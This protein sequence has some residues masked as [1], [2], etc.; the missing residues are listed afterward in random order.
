[1]LKGTASFT[2]SKSVKILETGEVLTGEKFILA[3]G[4]IPAKLSIEGIENVPLLT[5]DD[6]LNIESSQQ[7]AHYRW[8]IHWG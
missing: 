3:T 8:R 4:S 5:S 1:V 7:S 6:L 2:D